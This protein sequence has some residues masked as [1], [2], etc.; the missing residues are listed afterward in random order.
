MVQL[1]ESNITKVQTAAMLLNTTIRAFARILTSNTFVAL[2]LAIVASVG[3]RAVDDQRTF[4]YLNSAG[5]GK[6]DVGDANYENYI[7]RGDIVT[8]KD[9]LHADLV[10]P[11]QDVD[12]DGTISVPELGQVRVAGMS[13]EGL[14]AYLTEAFASLYDKTDFQISIASGSTASTGKKYFV[15]GEVEKKGAQNFRGDLTIIEAILEAEPKSETANTSRIQLIRGD[16]V[17]PLI[18]TVNYH[19]FIDYGD[20]TYNIIVHENDIIYVPPTLLGSLG[21]FLEKVF[22]PVKVVVTPLQSILFFFAIQNRGNNRQ[23]F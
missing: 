3:C 15:V 16:P 8:I 2:L 1:S 6:Q 9:S 12:V 21:N 14:K 22:Y 20:M 18:I 10:L 13:R 23:V 5:F 4:R 7:T 17:D 11:P 19:D